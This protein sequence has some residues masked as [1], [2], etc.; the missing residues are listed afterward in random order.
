MI[1]QR[2]FIGGFQKCG[3]TSLHQILATHPEVR[4]GDRSHWPESPWRAKEPHFFNSEWERGLDWYD[5]LFL[6]GGRVRLDSSPNTLTHQAMVPIQRIHGVFPDARFICLMR[7]PV[8]R[9]FSAWNHWRGLPPGRRWKLKADPSSFARSIRMQLEAREDHEGLKSFVS[10]GYYLRHLRR[11][12]Q[13][14]PRGQLLPLFT[15]NLEKDFTNIMARVAEFAELDGHEWPER[16]AHVRN[17]EGWLPDRATAALLRELYRPHDDALAEWLGE[18]PPWMQNAAPKV[19]TAAGVFKLKQAPAPPS[20][21]RI[22]IVLPALHN[23]WDNVEHARSVATMAASLRDDGHEISILVGR[24]R[25]PFPIDLLD[26][27]LGGFHLDRLE[28]WPDVMDKGGPIWVIQ[29]MA[30]LG[31]LKDESWDSLVLPAAEGIAHPTLQLLA[32]GHHPH[33]CRASVYLVGRAPAQMQRLRAGTF[34]RHPIESQR[35]WLERRCLELADDILLPDPGSLHECATAGWK[36]PPAIIGQ[37]GLEAGEFSGK[38][39]AAPPWLCLP[40]Q[41]PSSEPRWKQL[42]LAGL[43]PLRHLSGVILLGSKSH[44]RVWAER[45]QSSGATELPVLHN[46]LPGPGHRVLLLSPL[47]NFPR[48]A[49]DLLHAG[50]VPLAPNNKLTQPVEWISKRPLGKT[51]DATK[52]AKSIQR[53]AREAPDH[54][55]S[56][57][58]S[59]DWRE[60]TRSFRDAP[61]PDRKTALRWRA[62]APLVSVCITTYNR[63]TELVQTLAAF[64]KQD[65]PNLELVVVNDGSTCE[66]AMA[67]H[68]RLRAE[69]AKKGWLW[70]DQKNGGPAVGRNTAGCH[71]R[72][73]FVAFADDDNSPMPHHLSAL[74]TTLLV[75]GGDIALSHMLNFSTPEPPSRIEDAEFWW[76]PAGGD[77]SYGAFGNGFGETS[78]LMRKHDFLQTGGFPPDREPG[79]VLE[80]DRLFLTR[81]VLQGLRLAHYP[82]PTYWYRVGNMARHQIFLSDPWSCQSAA[83]EL[84]DREGPMGFR[85]LFEFAAGQWDYR[86]ND[87]IPH[88]GRSPTKS[89][90]LEKE[91]ERWRSLAG[92]LASEAKRLLD[93]RRWKA[94]NLNRL[95]RP[96]ASTSPTLSTLIAKV[97]TLLQRRKP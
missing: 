12:C 18:E 66:L 74:M 59:G 3:T 40:E 52:W 85:G 78:M 27:Y 93:S 68:E 9:A 71:A 31:K 75:G 56:F 65:W 94:A 67:L 23:E 72:G 63:T 50:L 57:C 43:E 4:E 77:L 15:A 20:R 35:D 8:Q 32:Q 44:A 54:H 21:Q 34:L 42:L 91:L 13:V 90:R 55:L 47:A 14:F 62:D 69:F 53:L 25:D 16:R 41:D 82:Q 46:D 11:F 60:W 76:M 79:R 26:K 37:P 70:I 80:E 30:I 48:L 92:N 61:A 89:A 64:E 19:T 22:R 24:T 29:S 10:T 51:W 7:D 86:K 58:P 88:V 45:L 36:L 2:L 49:S 97:E 38:T 81:A 5:A 87:L 39:E 1:Y 33:P 6:P 73:E 17:K 84:L 95:H 83:V 28:P 96:A